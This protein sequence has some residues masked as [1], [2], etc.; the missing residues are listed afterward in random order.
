MI[1]VQEIEIENGILNVK[2]K[3]QIF[4]WKLRKLIIKQ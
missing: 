3:I 2:H 1:Y 4:L